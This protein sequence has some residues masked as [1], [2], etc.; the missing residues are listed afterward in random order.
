MSDH[1]RA[2]SRHTGLNYYGFVVILMALS[3]IG[4]SSTAGIEGS[5][6]ATTEQG[7]QTVYSKQVVINNDSLARDIQI[8][9]YEI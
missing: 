8:S 9:R 2:T 7:G 6:S 1:T 4:C 3:F 5:M